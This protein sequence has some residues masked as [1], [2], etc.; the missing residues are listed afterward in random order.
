MLIRPGFQPSFYL[1]NVT[2]ITKKQGIK[3]IPHWFFIIIGS[4]REQNLILSTDLKKILMPKH[5][6]ILEVL[7]EKEKNK[8]SK[9]LD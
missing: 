2:K 6:N 3:W 8:R 7:K 5:E 4:L 9:R 1:V